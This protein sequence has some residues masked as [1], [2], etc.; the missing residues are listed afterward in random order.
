MKLNDFLDKIDNDKFGLGLVIYS[1]EGDIFTVDHFSY[2]FFKRF[3]SAERKE[4]L[5][6]WPLIERVD[7]IRA[8]DLEIESISNA[9][10]DIDFVVIHT[11]K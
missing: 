8:R 9:W 10:Y 2:D 4:K 1:P 7:E 11:T 3:C 6:D 5:I